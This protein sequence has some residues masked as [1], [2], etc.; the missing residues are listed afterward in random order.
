M[1]RLKIFCSTLGGL[2][3]Q[4]PYKKEWDQLLLRLLKEGTLEGADDLLCAVTFSYRGS[5]YEVWVANK[6]FAYGY[7]WSRDGKRVPRTLEF[8]PS[9]KTMAL[10][11]TR[12]QDF[13]KERDF[14]RWARLYGSYGG[15]PKE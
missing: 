6:W 4:K 11:D 12:V 14:K 5:S 15:D 1:K 3:L 13:C 2:S 7:L 10:L 9:Y 8:R